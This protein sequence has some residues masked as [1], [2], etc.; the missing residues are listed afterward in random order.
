MNDTSDFNADE[1]M[2]QTVDG[3]MSTEYLL[4]PEGSFQAMLGDFDSSAFE[5]FDFVYSK[6][7]RKGEPGSMTKFSCPFNILDPTVKTAMARDT[8]T[9]YQQLIIG[10]RP[11]GSINTDKGENVPLGQLRE[12]IGQNSGPLNFPAMRNT[13]PVVVQVKHT[14]FKRSDGSEGKRAEVTRVAAVR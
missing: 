8:V 2:Q 4:C 10:R 11:D 7:P 9:V 3:P 12:A 14:T 5:K 6:G 13:G 1:F